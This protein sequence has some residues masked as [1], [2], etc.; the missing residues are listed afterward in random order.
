MQRRWVT[1]LNSGTRQTF[2]LPEK[3]HIK[4]IEVDGISPNGN[5]I[6]FE[7]TGPK[8]CFSITGFDTNRQLEM[9]LKYVES[10]DANN[11]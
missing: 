7:M 6:T 3:V 10:G 5:Q 8:S 11:I 4:I 2:F 1:H 9:R